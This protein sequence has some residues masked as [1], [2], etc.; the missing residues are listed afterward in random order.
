MTSRGP[1][2]EKFPAGGKKVSSRGKSGGWTAAGEFCFYLK[3]FRKIANFSRIVL[4][5]PGS[6]KQKNFYLKFFCKIYRV[7]I[8]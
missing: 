8:H 6:C 3:V 2:D 7:A 1:P 4:R 5:V